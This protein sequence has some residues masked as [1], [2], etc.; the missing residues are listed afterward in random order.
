MKHFLPMSSVGDDTRRQTSPVKQ[1]SSVL[2]V[3]AA[4]GAFKLHTNVGISTVKLKLGHIQENM[5]E[6]YMY[7]YIIIC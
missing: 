1:R 2:F 6:I 3:T 5:R 7:T 4:N